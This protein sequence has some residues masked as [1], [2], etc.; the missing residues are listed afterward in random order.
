MDAIC[1][2]MARSGLTGSTVQNSAL[3]MCQ[4]CHNT[5]MRKD[6]GYLAH[7]ADEQIT[8]MRWGEGSAGRQM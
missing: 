7:C 6:I 3:Y 8:W 4:L 5:K 2:G 1:H